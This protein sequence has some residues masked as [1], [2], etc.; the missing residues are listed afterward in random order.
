MDGNEIPT[1]VVSRTEISATIPAN[2]LAAAG[3]L[4]IVVRNPEPVRQPYWENTSNIAH[5]LVPFEYTQILPN[6]GW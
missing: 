2:V 1:E 6:E 4:D 5:I 3:N